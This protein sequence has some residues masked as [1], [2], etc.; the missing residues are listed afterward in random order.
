MRLLSYS[1]LAVA[2]LLSAEVTSEASSSTE[3]CDDSPRLHIALSGWRHLP[4]SY[5]LVC[6]YVLLELIRRADRDGQ[7]HL[8]F[9]DLPHPSDWKKV[10]GMFSESDLNRMSVIPPTV[11]DDDPPDLLVRFGYPIDISPPPSS[12]TKVYTLATAE[13]EVK[14]I[15]KTVNSPAWS[16]F[17]DVTLLVPSNWSASLFTDIGN[18]PADKIAVIPHGFD[19]RFFRPAKIKKKSITRECLEWREQVQ[20]PEDAFIFLHIGAGTTNKNIDML[21]NAFVNI[22]T[23]YPNTVLLIKTLGSLYPQGK[24][25]VMAV[26]QKLM[27]DPERPFREDSVVWLDDSYSNSFM[28]EIYRCSNIYIAPYQ[29][30]GFNLPVLESIA[31]GTPVIVPRF[32]P[33]DD[34][35]RRTF[36]RY[37][38]ASIINRVNSMNHT[39][40]RRLLQVNATSLVE[41]M[42]FVLRDFDT[43]SSWLRSASKKGAAFAKK[44][45]TWKNIVDKIIM[46]ASVYH[47]ALSRL[48]ST[49]D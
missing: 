40:Y 30:E 23:Q 15:M 32:G 43:G 44:Y 22:T 21:I 28:G 41:E 9:V 47:S 33:T 6:Q 48:V 36:A 16:D 12:S 19:E 35:T 1:L 13:Y 45:Y 39:P 42:L 49:L 5:S 27:R 46:H 4:H 24:D 38:N 7:T 2:Y 3:V 31:S 11:D 8:S 14:D 10:M 20:I 18:V 29:S 25:N 17:E 26:I 34:F 37:V